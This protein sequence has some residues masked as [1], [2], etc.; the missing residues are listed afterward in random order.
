V[1]AREQG[2]NLIITIDNPD[3]PALEVELTVPPVPGALGADLYALW[4]GL[5]LGLSD[6]PDVD[7]TNMS[8]IAVGEAN[9]PTI[10]ND[11]RW[12]EAER[13][14]NAAFFWNVQG[15]G[16]ELVNTLL[17]GEDGYPKAQVALLKRN[18]HLTRIEQL[19]TLLN[20]AVANETPTPDGTSDTSTPTG[21]ES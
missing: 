18:G 13:V 11:L 5:A 1:R 14:I 15:G 19:T 12:A 4:L 16:I 2:R 6:D 10:D 8:K 20:S 3:D 9:W 21:S 17:E 7:A